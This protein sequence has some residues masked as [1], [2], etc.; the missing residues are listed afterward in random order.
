LANP[1]PA[2][3]IAIDD[4]AL[5]LRPPAAPERVFA[6]GQAVV[7]GRDPDC[8]VVIDDPLVSRHQL[9][10]SHT[11]KH[12]TVE[13]LRSSRGT[14]MD[15][16]RIAGRTP[17]E[18]AFTLRL[19]GSD[20]GA[21]LEVITPGEHRVPKSKLPLL[22]SAVAVLVALIGGGLAVILSGGDDE[23]ALPPVADLA[24]SVVLVVP[25][26]ED[27]DGCGGGSGSVVADG[28][29][30]TNFHVIAAKQAQKQGGTLVNCRGDVM[31]VAGDGRDE[32][33]SSRHP[34]E[35]LIADPDLDLA[36]LRVTDDFPFPPVKLGDSD[37]VKAGDSMRAL[38]YPGIGG[39]TLTVT[40]GTVSGRASGGAAGEDGPWI[41][42]DTELSH[43][44]SGGA[45]FDR[46]GALIGVPTQVNPDVQCIEGECIT[47]GR[48]NL[49]RPI[50]LAIP[51][52]ERA[53]DETPI[54][55]GDP[56]LG[57]VRLEGEGGQG[58]AEPG[59][60]NKADSE[61]GMSL[62]IDRVY[63]VDAGDQEH[64]VEG[65][66]VEPVTAL[67]ID[68]R[69]TGMENG[70][71]VEV[72]WQLNGSGIP[73]VP[74]TSETWTAGSEGVGPITLTARTPPFGPGS[75][76]VSF[77][78]VKPSGPGIAQTF[79]VTAQ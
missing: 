59:T 29:I 56:R 52:I 28:L 45:A 66:I 23:Q 31:V 12:W 75:Y 69:Y 1:P 32:P 74:V 7:V 15:G 58:D 33:P 39:A 4:Q 19:G 17:A 78:V 62:L 8:D 44:N 57:V 10:F 73:D 30:L 11:G 55:P 77:A 26:T 36:V 71:T 35:V 47:F 76:R 34:A 63:Y 41:K 21:E 16:R 65:P 49:V 64:D 79:D 22:L 24:M 2:A 54:P 40:D 51:L 60:D 20:A 43:G 3:T 68:V 61:D 5:R 25:L 70:T 18:G 13:D 53:P 9:R 37:A 46:S 14:Y 6:V 48:L 42:T 50:K 27:G 67:V 38:G 72:Q